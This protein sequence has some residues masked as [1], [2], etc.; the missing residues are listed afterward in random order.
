[1]SI[2]GTID[3][4]K[5]RNKCFRSEYLLFNPLLS[6]IIFEDRYAIFMHQHVEK[7]VP[8]NLNGP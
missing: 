4:N 8:N 1:M 5:A 6:I 3:K 2:A 7:Y